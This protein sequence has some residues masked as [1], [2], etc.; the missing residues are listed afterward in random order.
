MRLYRSFLLAAGLGL[1]SLAP[2]FAQ[3]GPANVARLSY[4]GGNVAV[5]QAGSQNNVAAALNAP[6]LAG[7]SISTGSDGRAEAQFDGISM[8]RVDHDSQ[9][10][11]ARVDPGNS[12]VQLAQGTVNLDLLNG[13]DGSQ[14][15]DTPSVSIR[16]D[17]SGRYRVTVTGNGDTLITVRSGRAD[18]LFPQ[19]TQVLSFGPTLLV[20]GPAS[21][22][23]YR[24]I[25]A[26]AY[27]AFDSFNQDRD[28][29]WD[30][31]LSNDD[32]AYDTIDGDDLNS[33][34]Q[35]VWVPNYGRVWSP[36]AAAGWAPYRYGQWAWEPGFGWVWVSSDPWGWAP[37]HYGR[38]FYAANHGWCWYPPAPH[39]IWAPALVAFFSFGSPGFN[40]SIG[41]GNIGWVPLA[42]WETY[43]PWWG[44]S[45]FSPRIVNITNVNVYNYYA[46]G[47]HGG[48]TAVDARSWQHGDFHHTV[49][50]NETQ[51]HNARG[52]AG[53][54]PI[55]PTANNLRFANH[56]LAPSLAVR[57]FN[58]NEHFATN[59][60][61]TAVQTPAPLHPVNAW[62]RF[63][64]SRGTNASSTYH[65]TTTTNT[66]HPQVNTYHPAVNT[67]HAPAKTY[68]APSS[69]PVHNSGG[70][71]SSGG[72]GG[73]HGNGGGH[74]HD[75]HS[76]APH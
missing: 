66:Y 37:Y 12:V 48:F 75:P 25:D 46:N 39:P 58:T 3:S 55:A 4:V 73:N 44:H 74:P 26:V 19:G 76:P 49:A 10:R 30:T 22:P 11:F 17:V 31:R 42:P 71:G 24:Y 13:A 15:I 41:F 32:Y 60:V 43:H 34:G 5:Q 68:H 28:N 21:N 6:V 47:R 51:L 64:Q 20:S 35:W 53:A 23:T 62:D 69:P 33:Y 57:H 54:L 63:N 7:D 9:V 70:S 56:P 18:V 27:D 38:W 72:S 29:Q 16:G 61:H 45:G 8:L 59:Y 67:Y 14:Q 1:A 2:A 36:Y 65:A 52:F 40:I 50:V